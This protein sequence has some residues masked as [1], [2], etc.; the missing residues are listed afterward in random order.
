MA[1]EVRLWGSHF[2]GAYFHRLGSWSGAFWKIIL[3]A[4][5]RGGKNKNTHLKR[6]DVCGKLRG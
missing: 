2:G 4:V 5:A 3:R 1:A 6:G